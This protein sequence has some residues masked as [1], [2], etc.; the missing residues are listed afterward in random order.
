MTDNKPN[1][2]KNPLYATVFKQRYYETP[3]EIIKKQSERETL[4]RKAKLY[5]KLNH[6]S[7]NRIQKQLD[8]VIQDFLERWRDNIF[9]CYRDGS[10]KKKEMDIVLGM[11]REM[12]DVTFSNEEMGK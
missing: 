12:L 6:R 9:E 8:Y 5:F 11:F 10:L 3:Q 4:E 2:S 7:F 1:K